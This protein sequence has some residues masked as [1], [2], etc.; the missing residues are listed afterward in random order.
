MDHW[1]N[2]GQLKNKNPQY[3]H[4]RTYNIHAMYMHSNNLTLSW[5]SSPLWVCLHRSVS[6]PQECYHPTHTHTYTNTHWQV[7]LSTMIQIRRMYAYNIYN[8]RILYSWKLIFVGGYF[9]TESPKR[10]INPRKSGYN[11]I[12]SQKYAFK[13]RPDNEKLTKRNFPASYTV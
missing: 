10:K 9:V 13:G 11:E 1:I 12:R 4:L 5:R 8:V 6:A 2:Y 3:I 7:K